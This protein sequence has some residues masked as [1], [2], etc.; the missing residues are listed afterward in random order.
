[1]N[2]VELASAAVVAA[3]AFVKLGFWLFNR[4]LEWAVRS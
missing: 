4:L 1:M 3:L 2:D